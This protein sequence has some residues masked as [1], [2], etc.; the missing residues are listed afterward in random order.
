MSASQTSLRLLRAGFLARSS[1]ITIRRF[2]TTSSVAAS[3]QT[4]GPTH[5]AP[6]SQP[7]KPELDVGE[8]EG[9]TFKVEPLKRDGEDI[10][11]TRARLL[12]QSRKRGTLETDLLLSTFASAYLPR[13]DHSQ[14]KTYSSFLDENDWDIYYWA[15]Q[16]DMPSPE[17]ESAT[18]ASQP[19]DQQT[20]TW[21]ETM[22]KSKSGEWP[23]TKG[24]FKA[25]YRPVPERWRNSEILTM[26]R[27]HVK[28]NS[29]RGLS[30]PGQGGADDAEDEKGKGI[31]RMPEVPVLDQ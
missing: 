22:A 19:E 29:A 24:A 10:V 14:L 7:R 8:L 23:S 18:I 27:E 11:T 12:Y 31:G 1:S 21:K 20:D 30:G 28:S 13:M 25:A 26:L 4:N 2:T 3:R 6:N 9:I 16:P 15:T 17:A 5:D